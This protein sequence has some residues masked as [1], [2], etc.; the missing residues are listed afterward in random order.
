MES[1]EVVL[2]VSSAG[3]SPI[4]EYLDQIGPDESARITYE[5][6]LLEKHG[7]ALGM[8]HVRRVVGTDLWERRVRGGIQHRV[9]Y[10]GLSG[11][12]FL[13][14]HAFQKKSQGAP[15]REIK[16]AL[17]RLADYRRRYRS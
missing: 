9:F 1:W 12:R 6:E 8:P 11:R 3:R 5:L 13:L 15:E 7:I 2:F 10:V 4:Q 16:T 14:L 17:Q